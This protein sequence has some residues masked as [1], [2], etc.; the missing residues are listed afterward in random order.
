MGFIEHRILCNIILFL[1][2][3][4]MYDVKQ[5]IPALFNCKERHMS[6]ITEEMQS[7]LHLNTSVVVNLGV[8]VEV[9]SDWF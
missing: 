9:L 7:C 3:G 2:F 5:I 6:E 1:P 8:E 4:K